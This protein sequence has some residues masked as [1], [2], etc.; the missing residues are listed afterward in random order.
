[1]LI[2]FLFWI[3]FSECVSES[4]PL[5]HVWII[6]LERK[7]RKGNEEREKKGRKMKVKVFVVCLG[8]KRKERKKDESF[9]SKYFQLWRD[10]ALHKNYSSNPS[11]SPLPNPFPPI[12]LSKQEILHPSKSI[13]FLSFH[14]L[15]SKH[16]L[17]MAVRRKQ[18]RSSNPHCK[19]E[20]HKSKN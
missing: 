20:A 18:E 13:S 14:F 12:L 6:I 16:T 15:P 3:S 8:G 5:N 2:S 19:V 10:W 9:P 11:E 7:E 1:M 4:K 17:N